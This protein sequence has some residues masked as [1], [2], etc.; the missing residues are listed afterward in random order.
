MIILFIGDIVGKPGRQIVKSCLPDLLA[1]ERVDF[2]L[3]NGE[4]AAGGMG[5]TRAVA[6][7]LFAAGIDIL[8]MGNHV[9]DKKEV[10]QFIDHETRMVRPLNYPDGTPGRGSVLVQTK[11]KLKVGVVNVSGRVFSQ[12]SLGCPFRA[13]AVETE[14]LKRE[15]PVVIVDFHAEATS[16]KMAMGW[17]L[18]GKVSAVLGTHT[19]VPT[20]DERI[21]PGGTAYITDV[22]MTGPVDSVIGVKKELILERFLTQLPVRFE[23]AKG[24]RVFQAVVLDVEEKSGKARSIRRL[25]CRE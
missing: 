18:D 22:G 23:V 10:Y 1:R 11:K 8:T 16:E 14:K 7:E 24:K 2:C 21:L 12:V 6:D 5:I 20:A 3:A 9:W 25:E 4:N 15:T 19:H 17:H 13:A